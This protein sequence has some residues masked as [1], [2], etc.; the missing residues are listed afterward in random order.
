M[1]LL[2]AALLSLTVQQ[3]DAGDPSPDEQLVLEI[4]NR[5][6][7][8]PTAEGTR[9]QTFSPIGLPAGDIKEGLDNPGS[10]GPR[11]PLAMNK[12]LLATARAHSLDMYQRNYFAHDTK[13]PPTQTWAQRINAGGY[14][15]SIGENI[16]ASSS[17][18][19][20]FLED[21][22][23]VDWYF[24]NGVP[25][26]V[27]HRGHRANLLDVDHAGSPYREIG[28]GYHQ[29]ASLVGK[30]YKD[31]VTQDFGRN[32]NGPFVLGV[33]YNDAN[34]NGFYDLG[35][36]MKGVTVSVPS[37]PGVFAVTTLSGGFA[38][39]AN[40][41]SGAFTVEFTGGPFGAA[42]PVSKL[43]TPGFSG[44]NVKVDCKLSD[45][46]LPDTDN[47]D[48]P[49]AWETAMFGN[50]AQTGSGDFDGDS[51]TNLAEFNAGSDPTK[52]SSVPTG[53]GGSPADS[54]GGGGGC[55]LCGLEVLLA[56]KLWRFRRR[57]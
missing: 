10:V 24:N 20:A 50:L 48:L 22:L 34:G 37:A 31:F 6:R 53:G 28:I 17:G 11:P 21:F 7:A 39:P 25:T 44:E 13:S 1:S 40:T 54:G 33:V 35:E 47:D 36:G 3:W 51:A 16:A 9:L 29:G 46:G 4:I 43:V 57:S 56:L 52:A 19:A 30:T 42:P 49:D 23:M 32:A 38:F 8:N 18:T 5:A 45:A 14:I 41:S 27:D 2:T 15:G 26:G 55:G 12:N